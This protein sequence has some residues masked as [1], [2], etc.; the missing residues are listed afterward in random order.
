MHWPV[1]IRSHP[2]AAATTAAAAVGGRRCHLANGPTS[3]A[4]TS[5]RS[6]APPPLG[7]GWHA[8]AAAVGVVIVVVVV[9][10]A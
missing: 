5:A 8:C 7:Q 4:R 9:V 10:V 1:C 3:G 2:T 6:E